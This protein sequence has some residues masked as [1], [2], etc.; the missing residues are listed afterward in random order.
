MSLSGVRA[1]K[2]RQEASGIE[3][4]GLYHKQQGQCA[5]TGLPLS[6]DAMACDHIIAREAG[7]ADTVDNLQWLH[8]DVN[9]MK[10]TLEQGRFIQLCRLI[11]SQG[12]ETEQE[13]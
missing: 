1:K 13:W 9:N 8:V 11:A 6:I 3:L 2:T 7:G 5:L 10:G 12:V 4:I